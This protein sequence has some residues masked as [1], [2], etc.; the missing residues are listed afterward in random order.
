MGHVHARPNNVSCCVQYT[1]E[2]A[3]WL[4]QLSKCV[5]CRMAKYKVANSC[6]IEHIPRAIEEKWETKRSVKTFT[7]MNKA[8]M[9][10]SHSQPF[11]TT[12]AIDKGGMLSDVHKAG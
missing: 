3:N 11:T 12:C 10:D 5:W 7:L 8:L 6:S 1:S 2:T 9:G 4:G